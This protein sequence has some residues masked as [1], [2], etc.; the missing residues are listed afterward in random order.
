MGA[1]DTAARTLTTAEPYRY[2]GDR[3]MSTEQEIIY[4]A[5]NLLEEID[6]PGEWYLD[7]GSGILYLYPPADPGE[8]TVEIGM[9]SAP[10]VAMNGTRDVRMEGLTFDLTRG[11]GLLIRDSRCCVI[12]GCTISRMAGNGIAIAG[13]GENGILGCDIRTIGRRATEVIGGDRETL[14][15]GGH[16]VENCR[17]HSFGRIDRTY[18]PAVQ[19][20]G[21]GN[22]V[23]HNL[24]YDGP[25][26]AMRIEGNDHVIEFND[27]H[28]VVRES[29]DQG[30]MELFL[31]ATYR[32]VVFRHNRFR[33]VGKTGAEAAVEAVLVGL[34]D[35]VLGRAAGAQHPHHGQQRHQPDT[36]RQPHGAQQRP[37]VASTLE[38]PC[39]D[40]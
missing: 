11:N 13:G 36:G 29:D 24:M 12:A 8:A 9:L 33:N 4:Y 15:P 38:S 30:A 39:T 35:V 27:V 26:S 1:I 25:S 40:H 32:G 20:E 7:R 5:F 14:T 16:F 37:A 31:N 23:A 6:R 10:M 3:G 18:T 28:S 21:V 19:L 17:I 2:G 22:R 34:P